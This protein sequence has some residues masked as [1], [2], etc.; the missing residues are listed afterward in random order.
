MNSTNSAGDGFQANVKRQTIR[1][2]WWTLAWVV[3]MA[4][5]TFG[6]KFLWGEYSVIT[7]TAI[8]INLLLGF[9]M[10]WA[11]KNHLRSLDEMHQKIHLEAMGI[12]LG[13]GLV[14]GLA[15]SNLDIS[16]IISSDAEIANLV[17]LMGL[18]YFISVVIGTRKYS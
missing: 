5:A 17:I 7:I 6:P 1:L 15:Y 13:V 11:N 9:G 10:I 18:T 2:A 4:I 14:V 8:A 3:S 12:T 16:N